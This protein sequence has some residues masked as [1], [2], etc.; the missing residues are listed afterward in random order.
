MKP[1]CKS[2]RIFDGHLASCAYAFLFYARVTGCL[3]DFEADSFSTLEALFHSAGERERGF[4]HHSR[5]PLGK[6]RI[7]AQTQTLII[8]Q[9]YL[10][11]RSNPESIQQLEH[12]MALPQ[13]AAEHPEGYACAVC[14]LLHSFVP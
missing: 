10:E 14:E 6:N 3:I 12:V 11:W 1:K 9:S 13:W 2:I 5:S 4:R 8:Y 7:S